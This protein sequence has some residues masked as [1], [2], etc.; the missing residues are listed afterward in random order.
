VPT[1]IIILLEEWYDWAMV[2]FE[3][4]NDNTN[5][6]EEHEGYYGQ[7]LFPAKILCFLL[8]G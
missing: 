1:Q 8:A 6:Q 7:N 2:K 3:L 4:E 5:L